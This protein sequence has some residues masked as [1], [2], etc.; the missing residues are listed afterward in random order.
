MF[1]QGHER[2]LRV[3]IIGSGPSG[4]YAAGHLLETPAG[5]F[6]DGRLSQRVRRSVEVDVIDRLPTPWG[7]IRG[8]VAPDHPDKKK[9]SRIYDAIAHRP[10]FRFIGNVRV[11]ETITPDQ[12]SS[13]YDAVIYAVGA[14]GERRLGIP[15]EALPGSHSARSFVGWYNGHPDFSALDFDLR[16]ARAVIVGNGNVSMDVARILLKPVSEL[17]KTDIAAHALEALS[18][19]QIREVVVLGRRGPQDAAFN[20]PELEELGELPDTAIVVEDLAAAE[21]VLATGQDGDL[22]MRILRALITQH[23]SGSRRIVLRFNTLP[24]AVIGTQAVE[25]LRVAS[26]LAN[27][28]SNEVLETGLLLAAVGYRGQ[29]L[30]GLPFDDTN[31]VVPSQ[32]GRVMQG[33]APLPG[34]YVTG[35]IRRGP[36]GIIGSNKKCARDCVA[37]LLAD[38]DAGLLPRA[39]TLDGREVLARLRERYSVTSYADWQRIDQAERRAGAEAGRPRVKL[40]TIDTLMNATRV[41]DARV[42][43]AATP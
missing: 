25:G 32:D 15:G 41:A 13:W 35:W 3:A 40:T 34:S 11:G 16:T 23:R 6:A 8:G 37:S 33:N 14:D 17:R 10:G 24:I 2:P 39:G 28:S 9:I 38:A 22:K 42:V 12:L 4:L 21:S 27:D 29:A 26:R 1:E 7:L 18:R 19:S 5:T 30:P 20:F 31:G 36:R 43:E